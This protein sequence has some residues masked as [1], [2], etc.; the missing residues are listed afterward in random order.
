MSNRR[1][2]NNMMNVKCIEKMLH[3]FKHLSFI[4]LS[5]IFQYGYILG[6]KNLFSSE[7]VYDSRVFKL[8]CNLTQFPSITKYN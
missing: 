8:N 5:S 4:C 6:T 7:E 3:H 1:T 2:Y